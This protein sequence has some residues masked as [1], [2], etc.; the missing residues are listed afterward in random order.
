MTRY[1]TI[2]ISVMITLC[3]ANSSLNAQC[4]WSWLSMYGYSGAGLGTASLL[5]DS[6]WPSQSSAVL[7]TVGGGV[8]GYLL[9]SRACRKWEQ[10]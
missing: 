5:S 9:G 4:R 10:D 8:G 6:G 1:G 3:A 7:L 2:V